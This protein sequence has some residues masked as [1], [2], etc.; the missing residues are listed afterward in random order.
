MFA[1]EYLSQF[2]LYYVVNLPPAGPVA[3]GYGHRSSL[4][5]PALPRAL[6]IAFGNCRFRVGRVDTVYPA[7]PA[8]EIIGISSEEIGHSA[9]SG[10][11]HED[12]GG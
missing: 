10:Q 5:L 6:V 8:A 3:E 7:A 9:A 12:V 1:G 4:G 2:I 11:R